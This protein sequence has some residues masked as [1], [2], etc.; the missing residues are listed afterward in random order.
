M[1][2]SL[3][4]FDDYDQAP[5][6][7]HRKFASL[8]Q[9][10]RR[11]LSELIENTDSGDLVTEL[12]NQYTTLMISIARALGIPG[13]TYPT[14]EYRND[15]EEYQ[16]FS[17]LVQSVVAQIM[18]NQD[19]V[20][21][22]HS[23]QLAT[24]TKAKIEGQISILRSLI[25]NSD[26]DAKRRRKLI[27]Q[28]DDFT[29]E[30]NRPRLNYASVAIVATAFLAGIQGVNSTL[31]DAPSAYQTVG[32]IL[33]WIGQDKDAEERERE[34][35]GKPTPALPSPALPPQNQSQLCNPRTHRL[36]D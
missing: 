18:L 31:A 15:W 21:G 22:K 3:L 24:A 36:V 16:A 25:E 9:I 34:R 30:L 6:E 8:E 14:G 2:Y 33:K 11:R 12:R 19:L 4:E 20:A 23:V 5:V 10:A 35:L 28:L 13:V 27:S 17:I 7:P 29:A 26:I 1:A 32:S